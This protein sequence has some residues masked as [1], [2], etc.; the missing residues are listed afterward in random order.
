MTTTALQHKYAD[1]SH[2]RTRYIEAGT[3]YPTIL[4]HGAG[5]LS[6][7]D[8]WLGNIGPLADGGLHVYAIDA[9]NFGLGDPFDRELSF[10]YMVD[11]IREF[12][13]VMGIEKSNVAG[14]S[15]GGWLDALLA[16]ESP[17][18]VN[19]LVISSGGGM[20]TRPLQSMVNFTPPPEEQI[21]KT[22][23][24]RAEKYGLD[25]DQLE[26]DYVTALTNPATVEGFSKVM[27]HMT[28]PLT[29]QRY[30]LG[31]RLP[32]I[33]APTLILWGD[34]DQTND[35][36]MGHEEHELIKGSKMI[37]YEGAGHGTPGERTDEW[38]RDVLAFFRE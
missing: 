7:A 34:N 20:A 4:I 35:I 6:G 17:E 31:R 3:G 27:R 37:V 38:N 24:E 29:R 10:A 33:K 1:M 22:A 9:L 13:D 11:H 26:K 16:Y 2:G 8:T 12:Q 15:M 30:H 14:H 36:S 19:K 5:F 25:A 18:R 21:R 23:R 28:D 32:H